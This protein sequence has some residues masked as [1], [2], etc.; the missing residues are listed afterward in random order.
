[1]SSTKRSTQLYSLFLTIGYATAIHS[2][3]SLWDTLLHLPKSGDP[4]W[5][6]TVGV[7]TLCYGLRAWRRQYQGWLH[8]WIILSFEMFAL[9]SMLW[10]IGNSLPVIFLIFYLLFLYTC[11]HNGGI[12]VTLTQLPRGA[13]HPNLFFLADY[14]HIFLPFSLVLYGA[15]LFHHD[16]I[17]LFIHVALFS[18]TITWLLQSV[19]RYA[20]LTRS[21]VD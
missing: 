14:Y 10:Q 11:H 18:R 21:A 16:W 2:G 15:L 17:L 20:P 3:R 5:F 4:V 6:A 1:M 8:R 13:L 9:G 12:L 7:W 19:F